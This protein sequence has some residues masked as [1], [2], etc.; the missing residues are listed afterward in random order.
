MRGC[1][2]FILTFLLAFLA[3]LQSEVAPVREENPLAI[4]N[5]GDSWLRCL[6]P[7]VLE[8]TMITTKAPDPAAPTEWNFAGDYPATHLPAPDAFQV[9]VA[10]KA[11]LVIL[12]G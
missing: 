7:T 10:G 2:L 9:M 8:L 6:S 3:P 12:V 1:C 5:P 11:Q 4:P